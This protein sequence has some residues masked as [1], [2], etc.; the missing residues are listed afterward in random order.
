[1]TPLQ[2][3]RF[4][5][6]YG[7]SKLA[8]PLEVKSPRW[9]FFAFELRYSLA[10]LW[11]GLV[12]KRQEH[13]VL[14]YASDRISTVFGDYYL[15]TGTQDAAVVSPAFERMDWDEVRHV[16]DAE[17]AAGRQVWFVDVGANLGTF[18]TRVGRLYPDARIWAFEPE[19][20]N[21]EYLRRNM[22]LNCGNPANVTIC[23]IAASDAHGTA[24]LDLSSLEPEA[25]IGESGRNALT[26]DTQRLDQ[27][28][29]VPGPD[30]TLIAKLDVEGHEPHV[31]DGMTGLLADGT[32]CWMWVE[33][34]FD[35]PRL[36]RKLRSLG[37][38]FV[39]KL[40]PYNSWWLLAG[41]DAGSRRSVDS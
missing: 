6:S 39:R 22:A 34:I 20:D 3:A 9:A 11:H 32:R 18:C 23:P 1:M 2:Q 41:R 37:F 15:R 24:T 36:E 13:P 21:L 35:K 19:P 8:L 31:L 5:A 10:N 33:D 12:G 7:L 4:V 26:V 14:Y 27:L 38:E 29:P 40:T 16:I 25:R 17:R 30:V 28:L